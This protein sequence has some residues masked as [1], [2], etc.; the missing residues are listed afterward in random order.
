MNPSIQTTRSVIIRELGGPEVLKVED[1][2]IPEPSNGEI[3]VRIQ[4]VGLNRAE[5]LYRNGYYIEKTK[6]PGSLGVE[7]VGIIEKLGE[8]VDTNKFKVGDRVSVLSNLTQAQ[9]PTYSL[10]AVFPASSLAKIP[11]NV[12]NIEMASVWLAYLTGYFAFFDVAHIKKGD[13]VVITAASSSSGLA[14]IQIA[15]AEGAKVIATTRTSAKKQQL[16]NIGADFVI[17]TNEENQ[18]KRILEITNGIGA[19]IIYDPIG[20]PAINELA[21]AAAQEATLLIYGLISPDQTPYPIF[22]IFTKYLT[23]KGFV[24]FQYTKNQENLER[25]SKYI[26]NNLSTGKFKSIVGKTFKGIDSIQEAHK[27]LDTKDLFGK[28]VIEF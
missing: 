7:G 18:E 13:F 15:K 27:Y 17:V 26:L 20:G 4:A 11:D 6:L 23:L 10:H 1:I 9:Y 21:N 22:Q 5:Q 2:P 12:S 16:L 3:R 19:N 28:A 8:G 25:A 14:A 24:V